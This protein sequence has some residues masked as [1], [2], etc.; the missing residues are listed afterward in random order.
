[1]PRP[2]GGAND[3]PIKGSAVPNIYE[4]AR[5]AGVSA[6]TVSRVLSRP[7]VVS[8]DTRRKVLETVEQMGYAPNSVARNLRTRRST[9]ILV[10]VPDISN[11]FFS[12]I[13]Q[14]IEGAAQRAGYTV[15]LGNTQH[16]EKHE[17]RYA[18][19]LKRKEA[20]G[21]I[22]L[23]HRLP[24]AAAELVEA[25][26]PRCA[27]VVHG[28]EYSPSL[29]VASVHI[30]N[31][32]AA[33]DA[34]DHLFTLGHR[35]IAVI[36]GP[37]VSPLSRDRLHGVTALARLH[38]AENEILVRHGDFS[39]ESGAS[40]AESV[41]TRRDCPTAV[42]CFNDEMA[43][44][45]IAVAKRHGFRVPEDL[46][47]VGFDDIRFARHIDPPLTTIAQPMRDIGEGTVRL[48]L[49]ILNGDEIKPVSVT[50]PHEL[51][52]RSSTAAPRCSAGVDHRSVG[53]EQAS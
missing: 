14:G 52:I 45:V 3:E 13:I 48:L 24:K 37:L 17:E 23:G 50:L 8:P 30:D 40:I 32:K 1:L 33:A 5:R 42:F 11:P 26:A 25:M 22:F 2:F 31:T 36:T 20:D 34:M 27:P 10:T 19:M 35:H 4:V 43:I 51:T 46:S 38:Q 16:E 44:G 7:N 12:L 6:S 39:L 29:G 53:T 49:K 21:L 28:C 47:V 15:L 9:K 18:R 41:L